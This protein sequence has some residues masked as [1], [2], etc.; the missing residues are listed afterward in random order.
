M[1]KYQDRIDGIML[2]ILQD[3]IANVSLNV[4]ERFGLLSCSFDSN[5]H[6]RWA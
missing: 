1:Y 5:L 3:D 2:L 4:C 6:F